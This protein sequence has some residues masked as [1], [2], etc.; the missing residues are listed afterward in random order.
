METCITW[1][2][3]K[4]WGYLLS[5]VYAFNLYILFLAYAKVRGIPAIGKKIYK[6]ESALSLDSQLHVNIGIMFPMATLMCFPQ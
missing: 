2:D 5:D 1:Y 4:T 3:K 6:L